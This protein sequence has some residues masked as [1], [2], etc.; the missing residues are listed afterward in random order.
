[1]DAPDGSCGV[2]DSLWPTYVSTLHA[3]G[4]DDVRSFVSKPDL[5]APRVATALAMLG[6]QLELTV[7]VQGGGEMRLTPSQARQYLETTIRREF[8]EQEFILA[9]QRREGLKD[10]WRDPG[11]QLAAFGPGAFDLT[12]QTCPDSFDP[13]RVNSLFRPTLPEL[14]FAGVA[15]P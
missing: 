14:H 6:N 8:T 4:F 11:F 10:T 13:A 7:P 1:M 3:A 2:I 5:D 15:F 12:L 9:R